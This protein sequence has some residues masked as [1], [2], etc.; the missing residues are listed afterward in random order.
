MKVTKSYIKQLIKEELEHVLDEMKFDPMGMGQMNPSLSFP[1]YILAGAYAKHLTS[2]TNRRGLHPAVI[3]G[4]TK[5][6]VDSGKER[7]EADRE[8]NEIIKNILKNQG[9]EG[10]PQQIKDDVEAGK[11]DAPHPDYEKPE[12]PRGTRGYEAS[13]LR[14]RDK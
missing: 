14:K 7:Q 1:D 5:H 13:I 10:I 3:A 4:S 12:V 2:V 11:Y 9:V 6:V 8:Y